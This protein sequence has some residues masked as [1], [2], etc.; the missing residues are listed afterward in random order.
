MLCLCLC[1]VGDFNLNLLQYNHHVT[2]LE[3][4]DNVFSH[5]FCP[6]ISQPTRRTSYSATLIDK[7]F[8]YYIIVKYSLILSWYP[9]SSYFSYHYQFAQF[10]Q[11][12]SPTQ[13]IK[14]GVPQGSMLCSLFFTLNINDLQYAS[15][16]VEFLLFADD[17]SIFILTP[18]QI[19]W[20]L[21]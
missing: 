4:I 20:I 14:C 19:L 18:T 10:D 2:T 3:F 9:R 11:T 12:S 8:T 6:L 13:T 16:L 7:I 21:C 17:T 15:K 5:A 1:Y